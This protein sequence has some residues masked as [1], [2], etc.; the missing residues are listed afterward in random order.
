MMRVHTHARTVSVS[1]HVSAC[2]RLCISIDVLYQ[3]V[4]ED[5]RGTIIGGMCSHPAPVKVVL[6]VVLACK[7][8]NSLLHHA[9]S[10]DLSRFVLRLMT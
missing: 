1:H 5:E 10:C 3:R 7:A 4:H 8:S 2:L 9:E 6:A